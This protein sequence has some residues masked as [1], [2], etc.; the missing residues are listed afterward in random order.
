MASVASADLEHVDVADGTLKGERVHG[1]R[2]DSAAF[3][4]E[5]A[6]VALAVGTKLRRACSSSVPGSGDMPVSLG[7]VLH[8]CV[9]AYMLSLSPHLQ[10][11]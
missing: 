2:V 10:T 8:A 6:L 1:G 5:A 7:V 4:H 11:P 9:R 3:A